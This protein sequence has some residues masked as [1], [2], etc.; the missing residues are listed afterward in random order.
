MTKRITII[1]GG[2]G[3]YVAA[4]R[5]AMLGAEVTLIEKGD[6]GGTCLNRGCI[7]TKALYKNAEFLYELKKSEELGISISDYSIDMSRVNDRKDNI[8]S[9]LTSGIKQILESYQI[10]IITGTGSLIDKQ[11]IKVR[12]QDNSSELLNTD[13][14]IIATGSAPIIPPIKGVDNAHV[15]TSVEALQFM[16][17]PESIVIIGGGVI[18]MEFANIYNAFGSRVTVIEAMKNILG[19]MDLAIAKRYQSLAKKLGIT[20]Q[21]ST[22]AREIIAESN[23]VK[24]VV[25]SKKGENEIATEKVLLSVGRKPLVDNLNLEALGIEFSNKG[26][27]VAPNY[28]TNICN[29]YAIGDVNGENMLAHAASHQGIIA[30]EDIMLANSPNR[31]VVP[32]CIFV[33]PEIASVGITEE[34]AK[35]Q[36]L[37]YKTSRIMFGSNGKALTLGQEDGF[38][39]VIADNRTQTILGVHILGPHASDLIHEGALAVQNRLHIDQI[40][41][42]IHAHPTLSETFHEAILGLNDEAIHKVKSPNRRT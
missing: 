39:K 15:M 1:G 37:D 34:Q 2:P 18:G 7:P 28:Q 11:T 33:S 5:A 42:T 8:V 20:I 3:G 16:E 12:Y 27:K 9:K 6:L 25:E 10:R 21:A 29:V 14:I 4:I 17:V 22:R 13:Y 40:K 36:G 26:I 30:V 23:G 41:Q 24:V 38:V 31:G 32:S 19:Q 35:E